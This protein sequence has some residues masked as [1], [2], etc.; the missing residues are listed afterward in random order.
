MIQPVQTCFLSL[1]KGALTSAPLTD[2]PLSL[3]EKEWEQLFSLTVSHSVEPLVYDRLSRMGAF[4]SA[5]AAFTASLRQASLEAVML[6]TRR[7]ALFASDYSALTAIGL[8]PLVVKG[9]VCRSLYPQPDFRPSSDEDLFVSPD[10]FEAV[11]ACFTGRGLQRGG[12]WLPGNPAPDEL[13]YYHPSGASYE[14]HTCLFNR[15]EV[16]DYLN[17]P[18]ADAHRAPFEQIIDGISYYTLPPEKHLL[19]LFAHSLKHFLHGGV[20]LRQ[21]CDEMLLARRYAKQIDWTVFWTVMRQLRMEV[22]AANL[23][24]IAGRYLGFGYEAD[25]VGRPSVQPDSDDLLRDMLDAGIF[26]QT[27]DERQHSANFTLQAAS[28]PHEGVAGGLW[29]SLFPPFRYMAGRFH[30]LNRYPFLLPWY[31]IKRGW[32]F[33]IA[34]KGSP[35][36]GKKALSL[37]KTRQSLLR[38]YRLAGIA[39]VNPVLTHPV[40]SSATPGAIREVDTRAYL[41]LLREVVEQGKEVTLLISGSSMSPFLVHRRD[42]VFLSPPGRPL[43]KGDVV[44]YERPDGQFVVH[45][46][47]RVRKE[48]IYLTG[49]AQTEIEGPLE[50]SRV[51][52]LVTSVRRNGKWI[53]PN[54][55]RWLFFE[56]IWINVVSFRPALLRLLR[57]VYRQGSR[58]ARS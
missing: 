55:V 31:Y 12:T 17:Q 44:C 7:T 16:Y 1:L 22:F 48:G 45:R 18:F 9:I 8:R 46:I 15:G 11:D 13:G 42:S 2:Q 50:P 4:D 24:D 58:S 43:R 32:L 6:Q 37:G 34:G 33:L 49:D 35:G 25:G 41:T 10:S 51:F 19:Y 56:R 23:F 20:G 29:H 39:P 40:D 36:V 21:L 27:S 53:G 47:Y 54:D 30:V 57:W 28:S 52:A 3:D 26:G 38:K 5:P 14:V